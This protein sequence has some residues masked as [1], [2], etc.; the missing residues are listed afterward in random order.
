MMCE[1]VIHS[2]ISIRPPEDCTYTVNMSIY[3]LCYDPFV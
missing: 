3:N 1:E 2:Q